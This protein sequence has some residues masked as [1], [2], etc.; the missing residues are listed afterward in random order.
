MKS[1]KA[2]QMV[3]AKKK[4]KKREMSDEID[5]GEVL[6]KIQKQREGSGTI[7]KEDKFKK[8]QKK[9]RETLKE[10]DRNMGVQQDGGKRKF[11]QIDEKSDMKGKVEKHNK[12]SKLDGRIEGVK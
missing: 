11:Q 12:K 7:D 8:V 1:H 10:I 9:F 4:H 6:H 5:M 3:T 2:E